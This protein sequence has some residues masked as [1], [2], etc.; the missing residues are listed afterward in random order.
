M[1]ITDGDKA[2]TT[3]GG[4]ERPDRAKE[5]LATKAAEIGQA[6]VDNNNENDE[7]I[8]ELPQE[9]INEIVNESNNGLGGRRGR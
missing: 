8:P 6:I 5:R 9:N 4:Q 3:S 2:G 1:Q 7:N